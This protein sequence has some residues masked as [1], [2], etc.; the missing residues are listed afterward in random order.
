MKKP[1]SK[2]RLTLTFLGG[3]GFLL[4]AGGTKI[5]IDPYLGGDAKPGFERLTP[6]PLDYQDLRGIDFLLSTHGHLDHCEPMLIEFLAVHS[7]CRFIGPQS[8]V[9]KM[10]EAEVE[11]ERISCVKPGD[12]TGI[13][14]LELRSVP[15]HD[16]YEPHAVGMVIIYQNLSILHGGDS[17]YSEDFTKLSNQ[18]DV[19][20]ALLSSGLK[21]YMTPEEIFTAAA[22]L[23]CQV[24]IPIHW[25]IWKALYIPIENIAKA[26]AQRGEGD[27]ELVSMA[28]GTTLSLKKEENALHHEIQG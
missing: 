1:I 3:A 10:R 15:L 17:H 23:K 25:D 19:D 4:E 7:S 24:L 6:S 20:V 27:F 12:V 11:K 13:G 14:S 16:P 22:D 8:S 21:L 18:I 5:A 26:Y 28:A 9:E 2:D